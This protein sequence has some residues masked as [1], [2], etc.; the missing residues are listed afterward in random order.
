[1]LEREEEE[2]E[3][4]LW[5]ES[6]QLSAAFSVD[7]GCTDTLTEGE[8]ERLPQARAVVCTVKGGNAISVCT[9]GAHTCMYLYISPF[10]RGNR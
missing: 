7:I 3:Q 9:H 10:G 6:P 2:E 5:Q 1:M 4:P 8:G